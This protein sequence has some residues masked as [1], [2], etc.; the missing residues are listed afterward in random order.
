MQSASAS[1]KGGVNRHVH[2]AVT[3][4]GLELPCVGQS[5]T[6][7]CARMLRSVTTCSG[8]HVLFKGRNSN[9]RMQC[10]ID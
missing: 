5:L 10:C 8:E 2:D 7:A 6:G 4:P 1:R 3:H 9:A